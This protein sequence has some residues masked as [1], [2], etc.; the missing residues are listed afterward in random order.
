MKIYDSH[1]HIGNPKEII[2]L[3]HNSQ[4]RNKYKIYTALN[5]GAVLTTNKYL[6]TLDGF[7][8]IP[9]FLKESDI[10]ASNQYLINYCSLI[11][12]SVPVILINDNRHFNGQYPTSI[13][14]EH[15][16]LHKNTQYKARSLYYEFLNE[17]EGYLLLHS[18]DNVRIQY[19]KELLKEFKRMNIIIA[20]LGRDV[21]E[22][23]SFI[24]QI[25]QEFKN[26]DRIIFDTSTI[27][28]INNIKN[29]IN[30]VGSERLL[31]GSDFPFEIDDYN[32][33]LLFINQLLDELNSKDCDNLFSK[34]FERVRKNI[35][36]R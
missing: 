3:L 2:A 24:N 20:H 1:L 11:N 29:A 10:E 18:K 12:N 27:H 34:S 36:V 28:N 6:N 17:H 25:L 8:A 33:Y 22:S 5:D 23:P 32:D 9:L 7:F 13:F 21:Y 19:V 16:L 35:Y 14:K 15:F 31:Y 30:I 4:Y 26:S